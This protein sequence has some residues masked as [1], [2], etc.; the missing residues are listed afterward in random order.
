MTRRWSCILL[1]LCCAL[2]LAASAS[3]ECAWVLWGDWKGPAQGKLVN[4][5]EPYGDAFPT[6]EECIKAKVRLG[7]TT[8]MYYLPLKGGGEAPILLSCLPD[9]VDPRGPKGRK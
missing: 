5:P 8:G 7:G 6:R 9:T 3:A 2:A 4:G 1:A